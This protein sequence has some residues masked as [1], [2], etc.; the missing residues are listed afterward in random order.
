MDEAARGLRKLH[1]EFY[2]LH[3]SDIR[4]TKSRIMMGRICRIHGEK[5][6][7]QKILVGKPEGKRLFGRK[8]D[9][10]KWHFNLNV[11]NFLIRTVYIYNI[12]LLG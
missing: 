9:Y 5:R 11:V 6:N 1:N 3:S 2:N 8:N 4:V 12:L 7:A 10:M